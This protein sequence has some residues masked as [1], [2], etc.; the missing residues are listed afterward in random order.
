[1]LS[2]SLFVLFVLPG[3]EPPG[4]NVAELPLSAVHCLPDFS[5]LNIYGWDSW[6]KRQMKVF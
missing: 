2:V 4:E 5:G 3:G 1:M 6:L